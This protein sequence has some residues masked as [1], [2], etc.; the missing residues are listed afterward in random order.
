MTALNASTRRVATAV[1]LAAAAAISLSAC[2]AGQITQTA[3]Q[4]AAVNGN[5]ANQGDVSLRNV[6]IVFPQSEE[7]SLEPGGTAALAFTAVNNDE[8]RSERL[9]RITTDYAKSVTIAGEAG[10]RVI[11]PQT[12]L[13]A[14]VRAATV[15]D[16]PED[17]TQLVL[18]TLD[19]IKE[20]VRPGLTVPITFTFERAGDITVQVPVDAGPTT[21]RHESAASGS[22]GSESHGS[23]GGGH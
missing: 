10:G 8:H 18:V 5:Y 16:N 4:V 3:T 7:Y 23:S 22:A 9:G 17:P 11:E 15:L 6:H 20:G 2:S 14:G 13:G 12:S 1:A 19:G 21:E